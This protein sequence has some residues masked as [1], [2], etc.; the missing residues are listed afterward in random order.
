MYWYEFA[1]ALWRNLPWFSMVRRA[2]GEYDLCPHCN[3][4]V[5]GTLSDFAQPMPPV[6]LSLQVLLALTVE[7]EYIPNY[8]W[9]LSPHQAAVRCCMAGL[10]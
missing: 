1:F 2:F 5:G 8:P 4:L 3:K 7:G 9:A 10:I 6:G